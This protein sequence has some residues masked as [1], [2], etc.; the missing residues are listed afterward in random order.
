MRDLRRHRLLLCPPSKA[1]IVVVTG[2][3]INDR[4][5]L[6]GLLIP[7]AL[8]FDHII[9]HLPRE[10]ANETTEFVELP[11]PGRCLR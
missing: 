1:S 8:V 3:L 9:F 4:L 7:K 5:L 6:A 10:G 11:P 2:Q